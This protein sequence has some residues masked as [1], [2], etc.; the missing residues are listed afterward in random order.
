V[1]K[2]KQAIVIAGVA[3]ASF[4]VGTMLNLDLLTTA[5]EEDEGR[6]VWMTYLT[7]VNA[8]ALP[9]V[10]GVNV[11]NLPIDEEGN[12]RVVQM[13]GEQNVTVT[14]FP[15]QQPEPSWKVVYIVKNLTYSWSTTQSTQW[16]YS[17]WIN[18]GSAII[19]GY[20][21]MRIFVTV[22]EFTSVGGSTPHEIN[23]AAMQ[24][25][26]YSRFGHDKCVH[27]IARSEVRWDTGTPLG[28]ALLGLYPDS[29]M[30]ETLEPS[31][32]IK[33]RG[34]SRWNGDTRFPLPPSISCKVTVG[35]YL[36]N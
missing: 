1:I 25:E 19:G 3:V 8:S 35:I 26:I 10:W 33:V 7:G 27:D 34:G 4:L 9:E 20:N 21:R 5:K 30:R 31:I 18:G 24:I 12:L 28:E 32:R 13:D 14:N 15:I 23:E 29:S 11:T 36:R 16:H 6:P 22:T 17:S 2:R